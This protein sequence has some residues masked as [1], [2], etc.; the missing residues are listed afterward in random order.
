MVEG[1]ELFKRVLLFSIHPAGPKL[2][3][4]PWNSLCCEPVRLTKPLVTSR[5]PFR[6][7][8]TSFDLD[9]SVLVPVIQ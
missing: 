6:N 2:T 4:A 1:V 5:E 8:F 9:P 3:P 7:G